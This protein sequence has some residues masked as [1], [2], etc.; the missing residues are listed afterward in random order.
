VFLRYND[1]LIGTRSRL[2]KE[3]AVDREPQLTQFHEA[4]LG[5]GTALGALKDGS[6]DGIGN[7]SGRAD[8]IKA[9]PVSGNWTRKPRILLLPMTGEP[10]N[11]TRSPVY[12]NHFK[13][14]SVPQEGARRPAQAALRR[15]AERAAVG[16]HDGDGVG[17]M[18]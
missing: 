8:P 9:H 17:W 12:V 5:I 10:Q 14:C 18:T 6:R 7:R 13:Q 15:D 4:M 16:R 11:V 3:A 1:G 2:P